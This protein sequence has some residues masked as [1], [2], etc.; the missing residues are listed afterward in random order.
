MPSSNL[1]SAQSGSVIPQFGTMP[2]GRPICPVCHMT[3]AV[4]A[5][6]KRHFQAKH[7]GVVYTCD[8]CGCNFSRKDT[9]K[10]HLTSK[11]SIPADAAKLMTDKV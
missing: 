5:V 11:H 1:S 9:F 3:F 8:I 10:L 4:M 2:D 6:A 7:S